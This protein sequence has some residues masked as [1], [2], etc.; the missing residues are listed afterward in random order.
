[1]I[2]NMKAVMETEYDDIMTAVAVLF[3]IFSEN[4]EEEINAETDQPWGNGCGEFYTEA[5]YLAADSH[6]PFEVNYNMK[7]KYL[8]YKS[9]YLH[10]VMIM[11]PM[12]CAQE[13]CS[14]AMW[15]SGF[16]LETLPNKIK[17]LENVHE[18]TQRLLGLLGGR[19]PNKAFRQWLF[20]KGRLEADV[21][22]VINKHTVTTHNCEDCSDAPVP[23]RE[24]VLVIAKLLSIMHEGHIVMDLTK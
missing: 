10:T 22:Y 3:P 21:I 23:G 14:E 24:C 9:W 2:V 18:E 20:G 4:E 6:S 5:D 15:M 7:I 8:M 17:F 11:N 13:L 19:E 16:V 1:M 12:R